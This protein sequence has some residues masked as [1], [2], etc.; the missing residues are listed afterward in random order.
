MSQW[1]HRARGSTADR[2]YVCSVVARP[3]SLVLGDNGGLGC[4]LYTMV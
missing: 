3:C 4:M 1:E 2:G